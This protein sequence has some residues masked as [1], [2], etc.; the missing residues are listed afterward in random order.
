MTDIHFN[1]LES[2]LEGTVSQ[3]SI[4]DIGP[5]FEVEIS[6]EMRVM[7]HLW[8]SD[9]ENP[10]VGLMDEFNEWFETERMRERPGGDPSIAIDPSIIVDEWKIEWELRRDR[11]VMT[12]RPESW[13]VDGEI[14]R[15]E[16][17]YWR[18]G[19]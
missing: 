9:H 11:F 2:T 18:S 6:G 10:L 14:F 16:L 5:H 19:V 12:V 17:E 15:K 7:M 4:E 1:V 3:D 8:G 13:H